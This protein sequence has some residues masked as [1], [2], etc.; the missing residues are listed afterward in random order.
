MK[1]L[2]LI[3]R[4]AAGKT[5]LTQAL[6][7][8]QIHYCKTQYINYSNTIIDTP[9]EYTEVNKLG[10]ALAIYA[11]EADIVGIV[12]SADEPFC[13]FPPNITC[14]VNR[15]VVGIV[16]GV[17]KPDANIEQ[18]TRWLKLC[19]CTKIFYISSYTGEGLSDI[20]EYLREEGDA[21]DALPI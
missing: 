14:M 18:A 2:M 10:A 19:G 9:G 15:E 7:G 17:D 3:G 20:I 5:T 8:E 21:P 11:Y 16:S 4:V 6:R 12:I 13:V 1:K